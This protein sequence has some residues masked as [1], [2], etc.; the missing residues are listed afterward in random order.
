MEHNH[1]D[2]A[3]WRNQDVNF[4][5][6][7]QSVRPDFY[8]LSMFPL[9]KSMSLAHQAFL[10]SI[11]GAFSSPQEIAV[12]PTGMVYLVDAYNNR[13]ARL[14]DP[15]SWVS[16]SNTFTDRTVGPTTVTVGPGQLMGTS[17]TMTSA[18]GMVAGSAVS[19]L[20]GGTL[21]QAGGSITAPTLLRTGASAA[22]V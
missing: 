7:L 2:P 15:D 5:A 9:G 22:Y 20:P 1:C 13:V 6:A 18:M 17:F 12:I 21:T 8:T 4:A 14:F 3:R 19:I 16:G 10:Q 11:I